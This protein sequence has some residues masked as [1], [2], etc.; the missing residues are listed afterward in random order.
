MFVKAKVAL[1]ITL[2]LS[3]WV[4]GQDPVKTRAISKADTR[5]DKIQT[6]KAAQVCYSDS[7]SSGDSNRTVQCAKRSLDLGYELFGPEHKNT[8]ALSYNY[9]LA[10]NDNGA[11]K[12]SSYEFYKTV[13]L[14]KSVYGA[15]SE[16]LAW[17]LMDLAQVQYQIQPK[18]AIGTH[19]RAIKIF[20]SLNDFDDVTY[21]NVLLKASSSISGQQLLDWRDFNRALKYAKTAAKIFVSIHG[22]KSPS[23]CLAFFNIGKLRL[24]D[25]NYKKAIEAFEK[26][27]ADPSLADYAHAFLVELYERTNRPLL[28][29]KHLDALAVV[30]DI[31][32][33]DFQP[34][35]VSRPK[36]PLRAQDR[37]KDGYA[38]VEVIVTKQGGVRD[39]VIVEEWPEG[40]GFGKA[41]LKAAERLK[42]APRVVDGKSVEV[43]NVLYK[44]S[45]KMAK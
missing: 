44:Y 42:Y 28:A 24:S 41:G 30:G 3:G 13:D 25:K 35:F 4:W 10:L 15:K 6:F 43:P 29:Q 33:R 2:L 19:H 23:A 22:D 8:A 16:E 20:G 7:T 11:I 17:V 14:Y 40:M 18:K 45:F 36:Y 38:I 12:L 32:Q 27:L 34:V 26:S 5:A 1:F 31:E 37:R 39:A 9:A 21:A